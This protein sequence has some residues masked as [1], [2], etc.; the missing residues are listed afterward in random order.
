MS[1]LTADEARRA[2][3]WLGDE[4]W[5]LEF[6]AASGAVLALR[7][8]AD[9]LDPPETVDSLRA[10]LADTRTDLHKAN[11][12]IYR[13]RTVRHPSHWLGG[14]HSNQTPRTDTTLTEWKCPSCGE[15]TRARMADQD[16]PTL[17]PVGEHPEPGTRGLL[18][19][20]ALGS[21]RW[22]TLEGWV[23][24]CDAGVVVADPRPGGAI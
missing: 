16:D 19:V 12:E 13:L 14:D 9:E 24:H 3:D 4:G 6:A 10:E 11:A 15:T 1:D 2:A 20:E 22:E 5:L 8:H 23:L 18:P 17:T 21:G 7:Q